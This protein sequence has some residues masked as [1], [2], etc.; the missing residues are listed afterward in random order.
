MFIGK[1]VQFTTALKPLYLINHEEDIVDLLSWKALN[2]NNFH[3]CLM[4]ILHKCA[5]HFYRETT[6][7]NYTFV[8]KQVYLIH[9][10]S[11]KC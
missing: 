6:I 9:S 2:F 1:L 4:S 5:S 8:E 7:E 3:H 11:D 10:L